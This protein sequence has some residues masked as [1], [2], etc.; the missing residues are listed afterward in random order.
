MFCNGDRVDMAIKVRDRMKAKGGLPVMLMFSTLLNSL[1][2][3]NKLDEACI[4]TDCLIKTDD[5]EFTSWSVNQLINWFGF[6]GSGLDAAIHASVS[7]N[8]CILVLMVS[9]L[10]PVTLHLALCT[11]ASCFVL[12]LRCH[13][14]VGDFSGLR[15]CTV[16]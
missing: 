11:H 5:S 6:R 15:V 14:F 2:H 16:F 7:T 3:E 13:G 10:V 1:F 12:P 4:A 9:K 8:M